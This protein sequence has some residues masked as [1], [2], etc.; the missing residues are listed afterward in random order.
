V[1]Q[2]EPE[3]DVVDERRPRVGRRGFLI[4]GAAGLGAVAA[5]GYAIEQD[6]LPGRT[7]AYEHLGLNGNDG[8]IPDVEPGPTATG[9]LRTSNMPGRDVSWS[10]VLPPK[11]DVD[12]LPVVIAL[13]ALGGDHTWAIDLGIDRFL[14]S[15]VT[16]GVAPFAV[17]TVDGGTGYWHLHAGEDAGALVVDDLLPAVQRDQRFVGLDTERLGLIG[18]SMGGYGALRLAPQFGA[19]RVR[20]VAAAS[21]AIWSDPG[22]ASPSGFSDEDEYE[23]Y[24]IAGDQQAL[25][26]IDVRIDCGKGDPFFH[27]VEN[28]VDGFEVPVKAVFAPGGHDEGYWRRVLP[29]QLEYLG[30]ALR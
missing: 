25:N 11:V 29:D 26:G 21:P 1:R 9:T 3:G 14:A 17:V 15:A 22:E 30:S 10:V 2:R 13:H 8:K 28:Y 18:W 27:A 23:E 6:W 7:W 5:G 4:G 19:D 20:A 24:S 12:G 16:G